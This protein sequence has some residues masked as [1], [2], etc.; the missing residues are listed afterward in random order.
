M[1]D[2]HSS[3]YPHYNYP[4]ST[5]QHDQFDNEPATSAAPR[6]PW[7]ELPVFHPQ[8]PSSTLQHPAHS[9][10]SALTFATPHLPWTAWPSL[11]HNY[12]HWQGN[13]LP[14]AYASSV[15]HLPRAAS[16]SLGPGLQHEYEQP[17]GQHTEHSPEQHESREVEEEPARDDL[18]DEST[19]QHA[20]KKLKTRGSKRSGCPLM[21]NVTAFQQTIDE[22][23]RHGRVVPPDAVIKFCRERDTILESGSMESEALLSDP[24][25]HVTDCIDQKRLKQ[26][27]RFE[28]GVRLL[29][30]KLGQDMLDQLLRSYAD[31]G[32]IDSAGTEQLQFHLLVEDTRWQITP[33]W[34]NEENGH[35][36]SMSFGRKLLPRALATASPIDILEEFTNAMPDDL[37]DRCIR[38]THRAQSYQP[39]LSSANTALDVST[40]WPAGEIEVLAHFKQRLAD[41]LANIP[42]ID[43]PDASLM[44]P[45]GR[46]DSPFACFMTYPCQ[47]REDVDYRRFGDTAF[48]SIACTKLLTADF[49]DQFAI[50]LMPYITPMN[51]IRCTIARLPSQVKKRHG[52]KALEAFNAYSQEMFS[53]A[54]AP[55][56]LT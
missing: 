9:A 34:T 54:K 16:S 56:L 21:H 53:R 44:S 28:A 22:H 40:S 10:N 23:E 14:S 32:T 46:F 42:N 38:F 13:D 12:S 41:E 37:R 36:L 19:P 39:D 33:A 7:E 55:F 4:P 8:P 45:R 15:P 6:Y 1:A 26:K 18:D 31:P 17:I 51:R 2:D 50:D 3:G 52:E 27:G 43:I 24:R 30:S 29:R 11:D 48:S 35:C 49:L 47:D 20:P 5:L 25:M